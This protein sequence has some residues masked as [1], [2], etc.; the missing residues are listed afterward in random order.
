VRLRNRAIPILI[1]FLLVSFSCAPAKVAPVPAVTAV[2]ALFDRYPLVFFGEEHW[3]RA[4]GDFYISLVRNPEFPKHANTLVLECGNSR[5]QAILDRYENGENVPFDQI[6]QVWRDTTKVVGWESPI[7]SNLIAAV[8]DVNQGLPPA[9]RIRVLAGDSPID[10]SQIH[11]RQQYMEAFGGNASFAD[12]IDREV[13][14]KNRKALVIM[15]VNHV[16]RGGDRNGYPDLTSMV[17][18]RASNSTYV[19]LLG[20]IS[21]GP[22]P[23]LRGT[24][25]SFFPLRE[26]PLGRVRYFGR[27][28]EDAGDAFL[29]LGDKGE[30]AWPDWNA[31]Q[32]DKAYFPELQRRH[33]IEFGCPLNLETWKRL[34]KP[35]P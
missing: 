30:M 10:W 15:G 24:E 19:V 7:Y 4:N 8:R 13:L 3:Q 17:E 20:G 34:A 9:N 21:A 11:N 26:T 25:P 14:A 28:A 33:L 27:R 1:G 35:C 12:V 5:Y 6:S 22:D 16:S 32:S 31:L 29:Y 2:L 23:A 18:K